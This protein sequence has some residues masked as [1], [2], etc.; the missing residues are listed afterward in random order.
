MQRGLSGEGAVAARNWVCQYITGRS[1]FR[2]APCQPG[3]AVARA[4]QSAWVPGREA[5]TQPMQAV[6]REPSRI[7]GRPSLQRRP[8]LSTRAWS[9][10]WLNQDQ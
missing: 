2:D 10:S 7:C 9:G 4:H 8:L 1:P 3:D 5:A 6:C